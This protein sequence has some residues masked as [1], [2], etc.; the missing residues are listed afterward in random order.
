MRCLPLNSVQLEGQML[1]CPYL[2]WDQWTPHQ[3]PGKWQSLW[4]PRFL[5]TGLW[6]FPLW[7]PWWS[8]QQLWE[9]AVREASQPLYKY[10]LS[11]LTPIAR[12]IC[13][14]YYLVAKAPSLPNNLFIHPNVQFG[15]LANTSEI[16]LG[17]NNDLGTKDLFQFHN[18]KLEQQAVRWR[19]HMIL[20]KKSWFK[21]K[22]P[23][24]PSGACSGCASWQTSGSSGTW[25]HSLKQNR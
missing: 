20:I 5:V 16:A 6:S 25:G 3:W 24:S 22:Q 15:I 4:L 1:N 17:S 23:S 9:S 2:H 19:D 7:C 8:W 18:Q 21:Q 14:N 13:A 10:K 12:L 11:N